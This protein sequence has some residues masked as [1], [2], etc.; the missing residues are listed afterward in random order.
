M[1]G[2]QGSFGII[3]AVCYMLA[4][5]SAALAVAL[6]CSVDNPKLAREMLP[7]L[8]VPQ[9][10]FCGFFVTPELIPVWIRWAQYICSLTYSVRLALVAEFGDCETEACIGQ[11]DRVHANSDD[12]WWYWLVLCM[13]FAVFRLLALSLLRLKATKFY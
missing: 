9:L 1:I 4:M 8:F 6:G 5:A 13:L 3:F 7:I 11:L 10:L 2:L 12:T